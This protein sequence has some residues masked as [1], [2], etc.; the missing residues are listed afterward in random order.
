MSKAISQREA[1]RLRRKVAELEGVL[2][3]Q[4]RVYAYDWPSSTTI[5]QIQPCESQL[6][7]I[8]TARLLGHAVVAVPQNNG[9]LH[10]FAVKHPKVNA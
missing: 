2:N 8:K 10:L 1:R 7:A 5:T 6:V 4:R 3:D 9:W